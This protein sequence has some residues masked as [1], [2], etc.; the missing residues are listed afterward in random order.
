MTPF[1]VQLFA[2]GRDLAGT[3][4][5]TVHATA[6]EL[7]VAGLRDLIVRDYPQLERLLT[8]SAIAVNHDFADDDRVVSP[9]DEVAVIPPVSGG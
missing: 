9:A 7:T 5:V 3:D 6:E 4:R 2:A 1:L 8:V